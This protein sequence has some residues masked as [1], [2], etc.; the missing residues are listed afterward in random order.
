M[1]PKDKAEY[2]FDR[3]VKRKPNTNYKELWSYYA[4]IT[5]QKRRV[6]INTLTSDR[7]IASVILRDFY[8]ELQFN[9]WDIALSK[10]QNGSWMKLPEYKKYIPSNK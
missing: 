5:Y 4:Q 9:G 2:W 3:A 10:F 1:L 6:W 8:I 7:N